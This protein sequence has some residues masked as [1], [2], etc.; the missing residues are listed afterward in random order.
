MMASFVRLKLAVVCSLIGG[1]GG[2]LA[3]VGAGLFNFGLTSFQQKIVFAGFL[4]F[5]I[6]AGAV[7]SLLI[8]PRPPKKEE[9]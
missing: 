6:I 7:N 9:F 1:A 4:M 5:G 3:V 2:L 8:K